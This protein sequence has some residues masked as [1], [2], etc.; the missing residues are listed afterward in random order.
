MAQE[1]KEPDGGGGFVRMTVVQVSDGKVPMP[2]GE[3]IGGHAMLN[4]G[5]DTGK[6]VYIVR[7]SWGTDWGDKGYC[8]F[9]FAYIENSQLADDFWVIRK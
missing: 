4:V 8:Y 5:Y 1:L 9:P 6:Q 3:P 7:N 2:S